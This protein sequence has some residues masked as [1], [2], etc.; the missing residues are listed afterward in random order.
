[1]NRTLELL[2]QIEYFNMLGILEV[3]FKTA[4][5]EGFDTIEELCEFFA[6]NVTSLVDEDL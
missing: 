1:M 3:Q 6:H 5:E 2:E 4:S